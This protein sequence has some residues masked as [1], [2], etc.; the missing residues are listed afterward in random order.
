MKLIKY[1]LLA[2]AMAFTFSSCD[3][4]NKYVEG[5]Q[6]PGAFFPKNSPEVVELP[7]TGNTVDIPIGRT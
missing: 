4:D 3:D 7:Q 2:L 5:A 6:S 1:S